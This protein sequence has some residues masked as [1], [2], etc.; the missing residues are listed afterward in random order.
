MYSS[1]QQHAGGICLL[2]KG[3]SPQI[4]SFTEFRTFLPNLCIAYKKSE[5]AKMLLTLDSWGSFKA[6]AFSVAKI[7]AE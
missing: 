1:C 3:E 7:H 2:I 5:H 4:H 6:A